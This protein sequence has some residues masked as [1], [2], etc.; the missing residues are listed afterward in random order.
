MVCAMTR[1]WLAPTLIAA[2]WA[3]FPATTIAG[4]IQGRVLLAGEVPAATKRPVTIDQYV[5]GTEKEVGDLVVTPAREVGNVVV[6]LE[7]PPPGATA[8]PL[9]DPEMDQ[10]ECA[11]V[12]RVVLVAKGGTVRFLNSDRLLHNLHSMPRQNPPFNRT[13]PKG[14]TIPITFA[15]PEIIRLDCDLHSWMRGWVVV[16][17]H[18]FYAIS[19]GQG[20][21]RL[22]DVPP[23]AYTLQIW[24]ERLG[25]SSRP[26]TVTG[27]AATP[28]TIE[29]PLR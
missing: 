13:Q 3:L 28:V 11:F 7:T 12:P 26:L 29:L 18:P 23:G 19:D 14:R 17:D 2:L 1:R 24:H 20:R 22:D 4:Q 25:R 21:F 27:D 8:R 15:N 10:K 9:P 6:W 5:C 16:A